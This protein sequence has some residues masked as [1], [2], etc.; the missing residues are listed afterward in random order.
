MDKYNSQDYL[1]AC[2][3][4]SWAS[5]AVEIAGINPPAWC[6]YAEWD[7]AWAAYAEAC[8]TVRQFHALFEAQ[9]GRALIGDAL[10]RAN[11]R[12]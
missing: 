2:E 5:M 4:L 7:S 10:I 12:Y 8:R 3:R 1:A 9:E 6:S 11:V